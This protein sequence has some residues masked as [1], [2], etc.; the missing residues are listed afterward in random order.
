MPE[1]VRTCIGCRQREPA[2]RLLRVVWDPANGRLQWD[3][4]RRRPGRGAWLHP[5]PDCLAQA[6]RRRAFTRALRLAGCQV[7]PAVL[8]P[9]AFADQ[10]A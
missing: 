1:P 10:G 8:Q 9:G 5:S 7:D 3:L 2:S 6:T 4:Q